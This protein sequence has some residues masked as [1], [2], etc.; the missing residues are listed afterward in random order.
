MQNKISAPSDH[1]ALNNP[2]FNLNFQSNIQEIDNKLTQISGQNKLDF[3]RD[4][5]RK[6]ITT[7]TDNLIQEVGNSHPI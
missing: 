2:R 6:D 4:K 7:I 1:Q 3:F 5:F